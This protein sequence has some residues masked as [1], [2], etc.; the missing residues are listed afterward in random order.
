M[1]EPAAGAAGR[2]AGLGRG[3]H[4]QGAGVGEHGP[5]VGRQR[6]EGQRVEEPAVLRAVGWAPGGEEPGAR[7]HCALARHQQPRGR[8]AHEAQGVQHE[9]H[10]WRA[11][12]GARVQRCQAGGSPGP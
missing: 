5:R 11:G 9:P 2:G 12:R 1:A 4:G 10:A 3:A 6:Q 7:Q 8:G